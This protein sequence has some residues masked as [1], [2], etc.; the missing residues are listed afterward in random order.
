MND[1]R[2]F[3][4]GTS[5]TAASATTTASTATASTATATTTA[6]ANRPV[7]LQRWPPP[8]PLLRSE[9]CLLRSLLLLLLFPLPLLLLRVYATY[10]AVLFCLAVAA[11]FV[12]VA[13]A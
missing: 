2:T 6:A 11:A 4:S 3:T 5:T 9:L 7:L 12:A 10:V 1:C 8:L 13:G